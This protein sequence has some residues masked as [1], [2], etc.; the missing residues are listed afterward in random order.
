MDLTRAA[1][2]VTAHRIT[3]NTKWEASPALSKQ[4]T[5]IGQEWVASTTKGEA[6][7]RRE[8]KPMDLLM[9]QDNRQYTRT[10]GTRASTRTTWRTR[11][12]LADSRKEMTWSPHRIINDPLQSTGSAKEGAT[13]NIPFLPSRRIF[14]RLRPLLTEAAQHQGTKVRHQS[15]QKA[16]R[17]VLELA[18]PDRGQGA[19]DR[20]ATPL[21]PLVVEVTR[22]QPIQVQQM[23]PGQSGP[24]TT[25]T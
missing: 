14:R 20:A 4:P 12:A 3:A 6:A 11:P 24:L 16:T 18:G 1:L 5:T 22:V 2:K 7:A 13:P 17:A 15:P 25:T 21:P 19:K 9:T 23:E 10:T 8:A